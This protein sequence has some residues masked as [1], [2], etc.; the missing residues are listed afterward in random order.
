MSLATVEVWALDPP[1][2]SGSDSDPP[3]AGRPRLSV[4]G[5]SGGG[6]AATTRLRVLLVEDE[7]SMRM[8][9]SFN[10]E[11]AGFEVVSVG[12]GAEGLARATEEG[13][14]LVLLDVMLPDLGGFEVAK[15]LRERVSGLGTPVVFLSARGSEEDIA[16]GRAAGAIDYV[17]KPF[18]P[19]A[20]PQRLREDL[21]E[22]GRSG[23]EAVRRRRFGARGAGS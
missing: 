20:L 1:D 13:F 3:G 23:A 5:S 19:V 14:D 11:L 4:A 12:T 18:D 15:Q 6:H 17:V 2:G 8:L 16:L 21:A 7:A 22:L 10:L 9:C